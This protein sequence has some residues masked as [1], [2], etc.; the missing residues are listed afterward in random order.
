LVESWEPRI[1]SRME[2]EASYVYLIIDGAMVVP[3]KLKSVVW[4]VATIIYRDKTL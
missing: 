4:T 3:F 1:P 2:L